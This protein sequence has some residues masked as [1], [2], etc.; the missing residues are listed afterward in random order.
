[1]QAQ[2]Y[3]AWV[4]RD[5]D[6]RMF[7]LVPPFKG[8]HSSY[9]RDRLVKGLPFP[10][11]TCWNGMVVMPARPFR[12]GLRIRRAHCLPKLVLLISHRVLCKQ[13]KS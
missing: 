11:T 3:D 9:T 2:L 1:V 6:G 8:M 4:L 7:D 10:V 12:E 5:G 13:S